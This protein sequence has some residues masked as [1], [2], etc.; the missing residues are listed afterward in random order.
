MPK[1]IEHIDKIARDKNRDVLYIKF[2]EE[3]FP[4]YSYEDWPVRNEILD[5]LNNHG[6]KAIPCGPVAR[7]DGFESYHGQLYID[8]P[9]DE[10]NP[11]YITVRD[12]LGNPSGNMRIPGVTFYL[13]PLT[14]A[15]HNK[16]HDEPGF[17][18]KWA[19]EF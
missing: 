17:W 19:A 1:L 9:F 3:I 8:V 10:S 7:E 6:I 4:G 13:L 12:Y 18:E 5:W 15:M 16:H 11:E 2:N 14:I